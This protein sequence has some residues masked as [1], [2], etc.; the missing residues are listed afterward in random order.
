[1][2]SSQ[3]N[4][5]VHG[6]CLHGVFSIALIIR[7]M[8]LVMKLNVIHHSLASNVLLTLLH[9]F[10]CKLQTKSVIYIICVSK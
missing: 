6:Y 9:V 7:W 8:V 4:Y 2:G 1:V 10:S 3:K 5:L